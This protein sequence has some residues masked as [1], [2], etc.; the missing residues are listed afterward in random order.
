VWNWKE[1]AY[2]E[3]KDLSI[4]AA[5]RKRLETASATARR[6][7]FTLIEIHRKDKWKGRK[8]RSVA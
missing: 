5:I 2:E 6:L 8:Y 3:V 1:E 7:G 4:E